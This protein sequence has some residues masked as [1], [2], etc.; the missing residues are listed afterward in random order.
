MIRKIAIVSYMKV[1]GLDPGTLKMGYGVLQMDA[2][3]VTYLDSGTMTLNTK[4]VLGSRL[5]ALGDKLDD[6]FQKY[7]PDHVVLEKVFFG[8]N[9][10][11]AFKLGM[12]F[13]L[14]FYKAHHRKCQVFEYATRKVKKAVAGSG[15]ADKIQVRTFVQNILKIKDIKMLDTS[16]ALAVALCHIYHQQGLQS[17]SNLKSSAT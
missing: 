5:S 2:D 12:A 4:E 1:I 9:P 6:L 16:D 7:Q 10:D 3:K 13:G 15:S 11:S 17:L 8:K 14:A